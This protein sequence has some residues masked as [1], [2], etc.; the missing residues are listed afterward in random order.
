MCVL[1]CIAV[2]K[3]VKKGISHIPSSNLSKTP[4]LALLPAPAPGNKRQREE[5]YCTVGGDTNAWDLPENT[6]KK[7]SGEK[8]EQSFVS[9]RAVQ[10]KTPI[11]WD[12][13]PRHRLSVAS[14][15]QTVFKLGKLPNLT[16]AKIEASSE[17]HSVDEEDC[18]DLALEYSVGLEME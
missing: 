10:T 8:V 13:K 14:S 4:D 9:L 7:H 17:E 11:Q 18:A 6:K 3:K 2:I 5:P 15:L 16:T 1:H 12:G